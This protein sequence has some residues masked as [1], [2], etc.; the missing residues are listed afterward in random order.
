MIL[1][2]H[3]ELEDSIVVQEPLALISEII[4]EAPPFQG[5]MVPETAAQAASLGEKVLP[6]ALGPTICNVT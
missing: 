6:S 3:Q 4:C 1:T 5:A 2:Q